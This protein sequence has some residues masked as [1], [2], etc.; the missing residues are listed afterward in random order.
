M[1]SPCFQ[2]L[3]VVF[4]FS[5]LVCAGGKWDNPSQFATSLPVRIAAGPLAPSA[6]LEPKTS[7][8]N[9]PGVLVPALRLGTQTTRQ[10][11]ERTYALRDLARS[12]DP[13]P[14]LELQAAE[15]AAEDSDEDEDEEGDALGEMS[16]A[17]RVRRRTMRIVQRQSGVPD[18][19][20]WRSVAS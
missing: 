8:H 4:T 9:E 7:L 15:D 16:S 11:R 19:G 1:H 2:R 6:D 14:V 17:E 3:Y 13:G 18:A 20:M 10:T 5:G 12:V